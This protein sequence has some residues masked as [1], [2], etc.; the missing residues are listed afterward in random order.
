MGEGHPLWKEASK[1]IKDG[2]ITKDEVIDFL[3][4]VDDHIPG[5]VDDI[6]VNVVC[7]ALGYVQD[8]SWDMSE[9]EEL[10][11]AIATVIEDGKFTNFE[12]AIVLD[13]VNSVTGL[14]RE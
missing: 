10:F 3:R 4:E 11:D 6:I 13:A 2:V 7:M 1:I 14:L 8:F 9:Q 5:S 12:A